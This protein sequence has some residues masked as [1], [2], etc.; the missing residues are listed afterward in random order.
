M[1]LH[2]DHPA[3]VRE[4]LERRWPHTFTLL[5]REE[6]IAEGFFGRGDPTVARR[7][8][9]EV[10]AMLDGDRAASIVKVEGNVFRHRGSH[11]GMT[12]D[13]MRIPVL[14]WRA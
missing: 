7:R 2:T 12:S 13:E 5:D 3:L 9:G 10:C 11:G 14:A 8:I 6:L 1:F 4:H